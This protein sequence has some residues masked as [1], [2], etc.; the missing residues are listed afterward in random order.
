MTM[1]LCRSVNLKI[2]NFISSATSTL[3]YAKSEKFVLNPN[4][5]NDIFTDVCG[6]GKL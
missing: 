3:F 6:S 2:L 4:K 5:C 1:P